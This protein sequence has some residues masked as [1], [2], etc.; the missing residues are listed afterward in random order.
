MCFPKL[1]V[2]GN[3]AVAS[4]SATPLTGGMS[5]AFTATATGLRTEGVGTCPHTS[6]RQFALL[7]KFALALKFIQ[8]C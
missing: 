5:D 6:R 8:I 3:Q 1:D 7:S 4:D 2:L